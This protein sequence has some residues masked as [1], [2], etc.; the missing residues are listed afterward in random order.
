[1]LSVVVI[2]A[3]SEILLKLSQYLLHFGKSGN[4]NLGTIYL[5]LNCSELKVVGPLPL[6]FCVIRLFSFSDLVTLKRLS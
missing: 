4:V 2:N 6:Y 1:M 5:T 3:C